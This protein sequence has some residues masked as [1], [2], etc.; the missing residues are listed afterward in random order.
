MGLVHVHT[1]GIVHGKQAL[2]GHAGG[3]LQFLDIER[4]ELLVRALGPDAAVMTGPMTNVVRR[5]GID[6]RV[7]VRAFVTQVWVQREPGWQIAS[8]HAVRLPDS[9]E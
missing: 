9:Q 7:E 1:T 3:F 6:E 4:G 8:F 2:L 5:R